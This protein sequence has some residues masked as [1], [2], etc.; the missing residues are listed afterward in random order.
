MVVVSDH[1]K[2]MVSEGLRIQ[3]PIEVIHNGVDT[4]FWSC[5]TPRVFSARPLRLLFVGR[6]SPEK[7]IDTLLDACRILKQQGIAF[8]LTLVGDGPER[9]KIEPLIIKN[10]IEPETS[11]TGWLGKNEVRMHMCDSHI[12]IFPSLIEGF[13]TTAYLQALATGV[14]A[15]VSD[16]PGAQQYTVHTQQRFKLKDAQAL[17]ERIIYFSERPEMLES[18]SRSSI[19]LAQKNSWK[20][21]ALQYDTLFKKIAASN[22]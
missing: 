20:S 22:V 14:V 19:E 11:I 12:I 15:M 1:F 2:K 21:I 16:I 10:H 5:P 9:K 13:P 3:A 8:R 17:A 18:I 7:G 4:D 6:F